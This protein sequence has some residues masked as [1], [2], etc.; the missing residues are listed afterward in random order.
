MKSISIS[1]IV[2]T[3]N[4]PKELK[5]CIETIKSQTHLPDEIIVVDASEEDQ[6]GKF[7]SS[8]GNIVLKY[9]R[10]AAGL[11]RQRNVGV[12]ASCGDIVFFFDD[13]IELDKEYI[14]KS[15]NI[16]SDDTLGCVGGVQGIDLNDT[17]SFLK[18]KK[19]LFFYRLFFLGRK[20]QY[21][22]MLPSGNVTHLDIASP[23]I[24]YSEK[25]IRIHLA[26]GGIVGYHRKVLNDF[27]F[28]ESYIGYSHGEDIDF[29][30]RV[31]KKYGIYFT[32]FARVYHKQHSDKISWY[33]T[34][35]F[36]ESKIRSQVFLFRKHLSCNRLNYLAILWSWFG[37]LIWNGVVHPNKVYLVGYLKAMRKE[38]LKF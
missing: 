14:E 16:F 37:L 29:S 18:G 6:S 10:T 9:I 8:S 22:K 27:M 33:R 28:D 2:C 30:H 11:T 24:R 38:I 26:S 13:D 31:S 5:N 3:I 19:R 15:L 34:A 21:S 36:L 23:K 12:E 4:R 7:E 17:Q 25:P 35:D 20:D 1:V 32:S